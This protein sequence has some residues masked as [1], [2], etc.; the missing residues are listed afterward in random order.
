MNTVVDVDKLTAQIVTGLK[1]DKLV[2][3][4]NPIILKVT[5]EGPP[6]ECFKVLDFT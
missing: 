5:P 6:K 1:E 3:T 4:A 2:H